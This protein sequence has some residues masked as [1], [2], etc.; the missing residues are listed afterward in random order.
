MDLIPNRIKFKKLSNSDLSLLDSKQEIWLRN[1]AF[2]AAQ[3][4]AKS[5]TVKGSF[6]CETSDD[7]TEVCD[8]SFHETFAIYKSCKL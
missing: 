2:C 1:F 6:E 4:I 3:G 7:G 8:T 5:S